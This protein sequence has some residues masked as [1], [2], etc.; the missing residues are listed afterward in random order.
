MANA[1]GNNPAYIDATASSAKSGLMNL[2]GIYWVGI[3][4]NEIVANND[5]LLTDS[6]ANRIVG[7]RAKGNGDGLELMFKRPFP[8]NGFNCTALDAGV[9]YVYYQ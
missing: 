2:L 5:F 4:S 8:V 9:V 3:E 1:L 6:S 7:K